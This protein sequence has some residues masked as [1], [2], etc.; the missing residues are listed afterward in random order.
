MGCRDVL[1]YSDIMRAEEQDR[2]LKHIIE[3]ANDEQVSAARRLN[4]IR[5]AIEKAMAQGLT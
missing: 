5:A 3:L 2:T 1:G 4:M